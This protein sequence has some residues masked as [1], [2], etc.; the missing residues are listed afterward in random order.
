MFI[1]TAKANECQTVEHGALD[2]DVIAEASGLAISQQEPHLLYHINDSGDGPFLYVTDQDG[3]NVRKLTVNGFIP[4]D[5][6]DLTLGTC[7]N[8]T[9]NCIYI[10]DIGDNWTLRNHIRIIVVPEPTGEETSIDPIQILKLRYPDGAHNAEGLA[11]HPDGT[12]Y[13]LT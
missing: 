5:V 1:N 8:G 10:A 13:I 11:P 2:V 7:P 3:S 6:E 4:K 12:L 9:G